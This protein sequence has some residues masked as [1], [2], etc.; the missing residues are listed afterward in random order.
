MDTVTHTI[1]LTSATHLMLLQHIILAI[2]NK[3]Q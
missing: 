2:I 3:G 1:P